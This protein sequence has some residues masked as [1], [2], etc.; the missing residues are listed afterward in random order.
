MWCIWPFYSLC[1][2]KITKKCTSANFIS[3]K[4]VEISHSD[5]QALPCWIYWTTFLSA[6]VSYLWS[7]KRYPPRLL[8]TQH[9]NGNMGVMW[10]PTNTHRGMNSS[11]LRAQWVKQMPQDITITIFSTF[12]EYSRIT[13]TVLSSWNIQG[14]PALSHLPRT[15]RQNFRQEIHYTQSK[16]ELETHSIIDHP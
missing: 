4:L 14:S 10:L 9:N 13:G 15:Q 1:V 5:S 6:G 3:D 11:H 7:A 2:A 16:G 8:E 12:L